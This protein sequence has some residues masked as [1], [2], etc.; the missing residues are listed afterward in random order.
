MFTDEQPPDY[1]FPPRF[2]VY[3]DDFLEI[4]SDAVNFDDDL[5][6]S[7]GEKIKE[8]ELLMDQ[9]DLP[10]DILPEYDAFISQ[11]FSKDDDLPSPD[12]EDK[13]FE[14]ID[15]LFYELLVFK[16]VP[17]SM[18]LLPFSSENEEKVFKPGIYTS[19]E[20]PS[21]FITELSH[22]G[23]RIPKKDKIRS[24]PNKN[25]K[26]GEARKSQKQLQ[27]IRQGKLK[28]MQKEGPEMQSPTS[29]IRRKKKEELILQLLQSY[30]ERGQSCLC[31]KVVK[32]YQEN[33]KIGSKPYKNRKCGEAR[34]SQKQLQWIRQGKLKKM[35]KEVPEMQSPTSF[36]RRKKKE[37]LILQLLQSYKERGQS[38]LCYKVIACH[39]RF[40]IYALRKYLGS[41]RSSSK[42][43]RDQTSN[44]TSSTNPTPKGRIHKSSKQKVENYHFEE[45]LAPVATM[46]DNRTM[47][48]MLRAPTEG[49]AEAIVVPSI[50][51]EQFELKHRASHRW[52][53]KEP[54]R[55]ITTWDDLQKFDE[56]FHEAWERYKALLRA[57]PHYG[58]TKLHQL[59][60]FYNALNPAD[61]DSLNAAVG[62]NLLEK[63]PQDALTIIENKSKVCNSRSKLMASLVNAC[64]NH[65][66]SEIAKLT[67]AVNQQTSAVTT[68]MTAMLKQ[69]QAN[70]PPSQV[71][72]V[73]EIYVTCRGAH[74]YYQCLTTG[75]NTFLEFQ[76]NIQGY[77]SAAKIKRMNDV[78]LKAM[79]NQI[80]MVKNALRNEMKTSIQTS[81]S[82][83]TNEIKNMMASLLQMNTA[84]TSG[85]RT[86]P[87]NTV[88]NPKGELKAITTR[89]GLVTDGPTVPTT[90]K[91][92]NPEEDEC[93]EETYTDPD[94]AQYTIK[95]PPPPVQKPKPPVQRHFVLHTRDSH[96]PHIPYPLRMLKQKRQEKYDIQIQKF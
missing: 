84:S 55:S 67:H 49:C 83:K 9:L 38:C 75:G 54:S 26:R 16:A 45:H 17:D 13:L 92:V 15:P 10:C 96:P 63:S 62:G 20:V 25:G 91:S 11:D 37:G 32:E 34:K 81:L 70:L 48:E 57:C 94:L 71:N 7:K 53:K 29:F 89:S 23:E 59:D 79:Q 69:L 42:L 43:S 31:Y 72:S 80:D 60:T 61:Q 76:D 44:P 52:L 86:L 85:S 56:S 4:K 35:Q 12:N 78:S 65:S 87:G 27:W 1:S 74:P 8:S 73:E 95:V 41:F 68:A 36:I 77:V 88:A 90:L 51:A 18:R 30:K 58:F 3:P 33:D 64:D 22:P 14:D 28:K 24:K 93:V 50:L 5:F 66:S 19:E 40:K 2:D 47:A 82:N 6:D 46:T 21:C 39:A